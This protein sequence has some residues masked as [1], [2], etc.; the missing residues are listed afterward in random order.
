MNPLP[1]KKTLAAVMHQHL[2]AAY[3]RYPI[4]TH[5]LLLHMMNH[6]YTV[7]ELQW[8]AHNFYYIF[9]KYPKI[10]AALAT[11]IDDFS[12]V[13]KW[14]SSYKK[15]S[16]LIKLYKN[17]LQTWITNF[18]IDDTSHTPS[19]GTQVY[20]HNILNICLHHPRYQGIGILLAHFFIFDQLIPIA[21]QFFPKKNKKKK[22][23]LLDIFFTDNPFFSQ[24]DWKASDHTKDLSEGIQWGVY[25]FYQLLNDLAKPGIYLSSHAS[26]VNFF[27]VANTKL[28]AK[29]KLYPLAEGQAAEK[30][31]AI[32]N[33]LYNE[34]SL[35]TIKQYIEPTTKNI[36][37]IGCG[38][39]V[40]AKALACTLPEKIHVLATDFSKAQIALCKKNYA[41]IP[42]LDFGLYDCNANQKL[43]QSF[44]I[45]F[46]R[47]LIVFQKNIDQVIQNMWSILQPGGYLILEDFNPMNTGCYAYEQQPIIQKWNTFCKMALIKTGRTK[48]LEKNILDIL[49]E[50]QAK[51]I[52][53][54]INHAVLTTPKEKSLFFLCMEEAKPYMLNLGIS[55]DVV[56]EIIE[57]LREICDNRYPVNFA[58]NFQIIAQK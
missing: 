28:Q 15:N 47:F 27:A 22:F 29:P 11:K 12:N 40:L 54:K 49:Y 57:S 48:D 10:F 37:E 33:D 2:Q 42:Q 52:E 26:K 7:E 38:T 51:K 58:R 46:A 32:L 16:K 13:E 50:K 56:E 14:T 1:E 44:D 5:P 6:M 3:H 39:G 30:R 18:G 4:L 43:S 35:H 25:Y 41:H 36:L 34:S 20:V 24:D 17:N 55:S 8:I 31:L 53:K 23:F 21:H 45:I 9:K 19:T